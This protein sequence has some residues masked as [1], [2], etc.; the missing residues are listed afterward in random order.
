MILPDDYQIEMDKAHDLLHQ[1]EE[2]L[3]RDDNEVTNQRKSLKLIEE[4]ETCIVT[5]RHGLEKE[6]EKTSAVENIRAMLKVRIRPLALAYYFKTNRGLTSKTISKILGVSYGTV[7]SY[8]SKAQF[9][10]S[11]PK[12][13]QKLQLFK[14]LLNEAERTFSA[15][16]EEVLVA[17]VTLKHDYVKQKSLCESCIKKLQKGEHKFTKLE[18]KLLKTIKTLRVDSSVTEMSGKVNIPEENL[19]EL[20][21]HMIVQEMRAVNN[22]GY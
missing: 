18:S 4:V 9:I 21:H 13:T 15:I 8:L 11:F 14:L 19:K 10:L 5:L 17:D 20:I 12:H 1:V 3:V 2:L 7:A 16:S 6:L 22:R